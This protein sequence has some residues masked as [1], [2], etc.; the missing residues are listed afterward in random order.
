MIDLFYPLQ[1]GRKA[2]YRYTD[3]ERRGPA[4]AELLTRH[5]ARD[6]DRWSAVW[7]ELIADGGRPWRRRF[8]ARRG[9]EGILEDERWIVRTPLEP[10]GTWETEGD[11][12]RIVSLEGEVRVPAGKFERCL[13]VDYFNED[14]GGGKL[15]FARGAG[16]VFKEQWGERGG[17]RYELLRVESQD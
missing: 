16:L 5:V 4:T 15:L 7:E 3:P 13:H 6:G 10:G 11:E 8:T 9:P 2:V 14:T 17:H 1:E 12:F